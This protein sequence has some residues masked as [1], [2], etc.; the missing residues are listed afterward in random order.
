MKKQTKVKA[1]AK[2]AIAVKKVSAK[3]KLDAQKPLVKTGASKITKIPIKIEKAPNEMAF[4]V[5]YGP[6]IDSIRGLRDALAEMPDGTYVH[7]ANIE[8]NDF[9][10]W[11][12]NVFGDK[13]LAKTLRRCDDRSKA[14]QVVT[15]YIEYYH[16]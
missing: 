11:I 7:H 8:K 4:W 3:L 10:N 12:E 6:V 14:M 16:L 13:D 5:N 1:P 2:R 15:R 9:A